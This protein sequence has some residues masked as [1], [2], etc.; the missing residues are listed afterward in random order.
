MSDDYWVITLHTERLS[1]A[2]GI[3]ITIGH[4]EYVGNDE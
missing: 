3:T 2:V 4:P 1:K